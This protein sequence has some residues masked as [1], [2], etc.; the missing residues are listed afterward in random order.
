MHYTKFGVPI[1]Y[2]GPRI[3]RVHKNW[4]S[5][6]KYGSAVKQVLLYDVQKG[7]K[8]G[9]FNFPP[10]ETF[11]GSPL[12]AFPRKRSNKYRVIH[13]LSWPPGQSVNDYISAEDSSVHYISFDYVAQKVLNYG[14]GATMA[15]L[16]I[17]DA[18]KHILVRPD[19]WDLLGCTWTDPHTGSIEYYIDLTLPFGLRSSAKLF[20]EFAYA[21]KLCMIYGG[22][23]DVE[24]YLDDYVTIG[25]PDSPVADNNLD[26]MLSTC[27][28][29]GFEVN[30]S[31]ISRPNSVMEFLGIVIDSR[32]Q[33]VRISEDRLRDI[34]CEL[35]NFLSKK[36]CSK[37]CLLSLIGKLI[38]VSRVVRTGR[39]FVRR[40]IELSKHIKFL[41]YRVRINQACRADMEWWI[42]YLPTWNGVG[43]IPDAIWTTNVD[44]ELY[45][46]A[47]DKAIGCYFG[48]E[49]CYLPFTGKYSY[50]KQQHINFRE[51]FAIAVALTTWAPRLKQKRVLFHCDNTAAVQV[52]Q[53][54]V[55]RD[56][57]MM[58]LIR[59]I[60]F[61]CARYQFECSAVHISSVDNIIADSISRFQWGRFRE[62]APSAMPSPVTPVV[63]DYKSY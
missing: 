61:I 20:T 5:A 15:K 46:D 48:G 31:K 3:S 30:P 24:H 33:E 35:R 14:V 16:D 50:L 13:D 25:P 23:T 41:H 26:I 44:L 19:D 18:Y 59:N 4:N 17:S 2:N 54:G 12:G 52:L 42:T 51:L 11:V 28:L 43:L 56:S 62:A 9:P 37:R 21:L 27:S 58:H 8:A 29:I 1:G 7:R 38:F 10:F 45:T 39:S 32:K 49:W 55:S 47:S 22:A 57:Q 63:T 53:S 34:M 6:Y 40:M 60:L 36:Y